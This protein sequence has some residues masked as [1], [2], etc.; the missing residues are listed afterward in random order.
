[1]VVH[2]AADLAFAE[3]M[4][5]AAGQGRSGAGPALLLQ[6]GH[7]SPEGQALAIKHVRSHGRWR[8]SLQTHKLLGVR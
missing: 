6:P 7:G 8:L 2:E 5:A 1:M 3:A 4:A